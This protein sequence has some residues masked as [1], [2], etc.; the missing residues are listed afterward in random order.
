[1]VTHATI[2]MWKIP[3][4]EEF[5][6]LQSL[7]SQSIGHDRVTEQK[8]THYWNIKRFLFFLIIIFIIKLP[9]IDVFCHFFQCYLL[10][11]TALMK[12]FFW[13]FSLCRLPLHPV[14]V[15]IIL[16]FLLTFWFAKYLKSLFYLPSLN[17]TFSPHLKQMR[18]SEYCTF[19]HHSSFLCCYGLGIHVHSGL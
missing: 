11:T 16:F 12:L 3:R 9:L 18:T 8:H 6:G 17:D 10:P 14:I 15:L 1:M 5:G 4:K 19:L 7:G 13:L 2:P